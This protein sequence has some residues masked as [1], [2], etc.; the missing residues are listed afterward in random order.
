MLRPSKLILRVI[1][2][3][4]IVLQLAKLN[5]KTDDN[6]K[7]IAEFK[8]DMLKK[9][10]TDSLNSR[11]KVEMILNETTKFVDGSENVKNGFRDFV[12]LLIAWAIIE[13]TFSI[14]EKRNSKKHLQG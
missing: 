10:Q 5:R 6:A 9:A 14:I 7:S 13:T 11:A 12:R 1:F 2:I 8:F 3:I 4:L